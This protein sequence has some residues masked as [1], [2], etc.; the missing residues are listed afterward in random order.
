MNWIILSATVSIIFFIGYSYGSK[1]LDELKEGFTI[2]DRLSGK[3][4]CWKLFQVDE[5]DMLK[6]GQL[7]CEIVRNSEICWRLVLEKRK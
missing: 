5:I 3:R 6:K 1:K 4:E 2:C 7:H